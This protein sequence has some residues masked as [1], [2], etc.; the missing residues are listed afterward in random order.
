MTFPE[1]YAV[2]VHCGG[3]ATKTAPGGSFSIRKREYYSFI[4][5]ICDLDV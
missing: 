5:S 2:I 3:F 1:R 4:F